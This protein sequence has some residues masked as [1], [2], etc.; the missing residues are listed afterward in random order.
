MRDYNMLDAD[1]VLFG[2]ENPFVKRLTLE[3]LIRMT[4]SN[5]I[6]WQHALESRTLKL[7][8]ALLKY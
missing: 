3:L 2:L 5:A 7:L 4:I 1:F 8:I 6:P